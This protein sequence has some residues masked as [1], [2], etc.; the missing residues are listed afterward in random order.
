MEKLKFRIGFTNCMAVSSEGR[1]GGLALYWNNNSQLEILNFSKHHIH[2]L[3]TN[4]EGDDREGVSWYLTGIYGHPEA[5]RR[6]ETWN[7]IKSLAVTSDRGW[8]MMGDFNEI[9]SNYEKRG[10]RI[11][12][13]C[14]MRDFRQFLDECEMMDLGFN[15]NQF[16]W[17]NGRD[18]QHSICERLDH[19]LA[20][21]QW[22]SLNLLAEVNHGF[23]PYSDHVPIILTTQD[24]RRHMGRQNTFKFEAIWADEPD[25]KKVWNRAYFGNVRRNIEQA[26]L[27]L[28]KLLHS[29][30]CHLRSDCLRDARSE[31]QKWLERDEL[32]WKQRA[33]VK[34]LQTGSLRDQI[35]TNYFHQLFNST[36]QQG[37]TDFLDD[38]A[39]RVS[40]D[41]N[42]SLTKTYSAAEVSQALKQMNPL[43]APGPDDMAPIFYQKYW[44]IIGGEA[45]F[46]PS[47][48]ITDN[49]LVAYKMVHFLRQK[50]KGK[51]GYMSLKLDMS[52]AYD[53]VEWNF[54]E[55][56]MLMV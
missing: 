49:V 14:Q 51:Q 26:R 39:G 2:A 35:I 1:S 17:W 38:L 41:M 30:P 44:S 21:M 28:R 5:S 20:N 43:S 3:V 42:S 55:K 16:T 34:W 27:Q 47:R 24:D 52:K 40:D 25:C 31:L 36:G 22:K 33:K 7:M 18:Q 23:A 13:E 54:L 56:V 8:L 6:L 4:K 37:Q 11:R 46:V 19:F 50:R 12:Q 45:A 15:G 32:L 29:N 53:R 10:G 48:L 9:L